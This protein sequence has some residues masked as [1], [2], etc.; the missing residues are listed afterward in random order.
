VL[1]YARG[2]G[3]RGEDDT[4][5]LEELLAEAT[6]RGLLSASDA[7][8]ARL[9]SHSSLDLDADPESDNEVAAIDLDADSAH[10]MTSV[11]PPSRCDASTA[12]PI[13]FTCCYKSGCGGN[14]HGRGVCH[15][16][17]V[18]IPPCRRKGCP[19]KSVHRGVCARHSLE[20]RLLTARR[21][22]SFHP[23]LIP[24][25]RD[26][27]AGSLHGNRSAVEVAKDFLEALL[28]QK[29]MD[30]PGY[31]AIVERYIS[32]VRGEIE[33]LA[34]KRAKELEKAL[35]TAV[36][37]GIEQETSS[38]LANV[39]KERDDDL[40]LVEQMSN[41]TC[42]DKCRKIVEE[43]CFER[44]EEIKENYSSFVESK[45][46]EVTRRV[47]AK[48]DLDLLRLNDNLQ[49]AEG[50]RKNPSNRNDS[51]DIICDGNGKSVAI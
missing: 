5:S 37:E 40:L 17:Y 6:S 23:V 8:T 11:H 30:Y 36:D 14:V 47:G 7:G 46:E 15:K 12:R 1:P 48:Y 26:I 29:P 2:Q 4:A 19:N 27:Y 9:T 13:I 44:V 10:T 24:I 38:N 50:W 20:D 43:N 39:E 25:L 42:K 3:R 45:K 21:A 16:H 49:E 18:A 32:E 28:L 22:K 35:P 31:D 34:S 51:D 41:L 33:T